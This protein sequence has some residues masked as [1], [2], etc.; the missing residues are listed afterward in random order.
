MATTSTQDTVEN[1]AIDRRD[2]VDDKPRK[3]Q[4]WLGEIAAAKKRDKTWASRGSKVI[5]RYRDERDMDRDSAKGERRASI[6]WSNTEILKAALFQGLGN[7]DV[8]KRF[9]KKGQDAR[10]ARTAALVLERCLSACT[11]LYDAD[12]QIEAAVEDM[13]LPG[14]GTGWVVYEAEVGT[15]EGRDDEGDDHVD[16]APA[17][18]SG[19]QP[20]LPGGGLLAGQGAVPVPQAPKPQA[21]EIISQTVRIDHVYWEDYLCS[22]GRKDSDVWWKARAHNYSRDELRKYWPEHADKIPL[23]VSIGGYDQRKAKGPDDDDTFKRA[24]VW[25]IWDKSKKQR[26]Y[27]AEGYAA[28]LA[29]EPDPYGLKDFWPTVTPLYGVKTTSSLTPIPEFTLYQDQAD[30]LDLITTRLARLINNLKRRGVYDA[31]AEGSDAALSQ[32]AYAGDDQF[33]PYRNFA[34]L[35]EK[36]GLKN[37]FQTEDLVPTIQVVEKLY[38]QRAMLV[39]TIYEVTGISDV[40][41]GASNPDE[42]ATAQRI[43]GQFGSLRLQ[44]RQKAVQTFIRDL[45]RIKAEIMAEHFTREMLQEMSGIDLPMRAEVEQAKQQMA[46]VEQQIQAASQP[47]QPPPNGM[48]PQPPP[49]MPDPQHVQTLMT[50]ASAVPWE[51]VAAILRSD[52]RRGYKVDIET[53]A[54]AQVDSDME[55]QNRIEFLSTMQGF[56]ERVLPATMQMPAIAPLAKELMMFAVGAFKV[57][58]TLEETFDDV[59][60]QIEQMAKQQAAQGPPPDPVADAKAKQIEVQTQATQ[61]QMQA[62]QQMAQADLMA[63]QKKA[64]L[65][66]MKTQAE[67][68]NAAMEREAKAQEQ[69]ANF[70]IAQAEQRRKTQETQATIG[71]KREQAQADAALAREQ[72]WFQMQRDMAKANAD[73]QSGQLKAEMERA[74]QQHKMFNDHRQFQHKQQADHAKLRTRQNMVH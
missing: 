10:A 72:A 29:R 20:P 64:Q 62:D 56:L 8:R 36:G 30:E 50:T 5:A 74:M 51:D 23:D 2:D 45:Y 41:R 52:A 6:L 49:A 71:L 69:A 26:V 53:E 42:T 67:M 24:R 15:P 19:G 73:L 25:E 4:F 68:Q 18:P 37:V 31:G 58:R 9:P 40:I 57:G 38:Q 7:P 1:A 60:E 17:L 66:Q 12:S 16:P 47:Q 11:D 13:L 35:M 14:R 33:L 39:Q 43:K 65:E 63:M 27:V 21:E 55:K 34:V 22:A 32:L 46:A 59:F 48:A 3:S 70:G 44:K 28:E 61:A 54:T